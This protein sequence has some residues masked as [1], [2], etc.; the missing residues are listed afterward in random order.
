MQACVAQRALEK[1]RSSSVNVR[2]NCTPYTFEC[3]VFIFLQI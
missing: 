2:I 1:D 3:I